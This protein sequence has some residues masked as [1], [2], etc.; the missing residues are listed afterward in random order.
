[1]DLFEHLTESGNVISAEGSTSFPS[2][3]L[4]VEPGHRHGAEASLACRVLEDRSYDEP[5]SDLV[6]R[7]LV[8][9]HLFNPPNKGFCLFN[10]QRMLDS[11]NRWEDEKPRSGH[12]RSAAEQRAR[13][14]TR[15]RRG[16]TLAAKQAKSTVTGV[17][18][19]NKPT[20][21]I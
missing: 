17:M 4:P 8:V 2:I 14:M 6:Y 20:T 10:H 3:S 9:F 1:M 16:G 7:F 18:E 12:Q 15:R 13:G 11:K 21:N 19:N 5:L